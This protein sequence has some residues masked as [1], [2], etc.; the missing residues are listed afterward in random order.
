MA[1]TCNAAHQNDGWQTQADRLTFTH[2]ALGVAA[3][4]LTDKARRRPLS[5]PTRSRAGAA[6]STSQDVPPISQLATEL[7][8]AR[9]K[10]AGLERQ[11]ERKAKLAEKMQEH[12]D[13]WHEQATIAESRIADLE[14]ELNDA[15]ATVSF[16]HNENCSLQASLDLLLSENSRQSRCLAESKVVMDDVQC[17]LASVKTQLA[18]IETERD[19]LFA[20]ARETSQLHQAEIGKLKTRLASMSSGAIAA[21]Q[22]LKRVRRS[23][24]ER[25]RL[26]QNAIGANDRRVQ[27]LKHAL[28]QLVDLANTSLTTVKARDVEDG[29]DDLVLGRPVLAKSNGHVGRDAAISSA[30]CPSFTAGLLAETITF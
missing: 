14:S 1:L 18:A 30:S 23:I 4:T 26:I 27:E 20:A 25:L 17:E 15:R 7:E 29:A 11:L 3:I 10:V 5:Q 13:A 28:T 19:Q 22:L 21:E 9:A 12:L 16:Q 8:L 6:S 24:V 2:G